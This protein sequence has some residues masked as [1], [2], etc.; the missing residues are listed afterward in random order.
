MRTI[1][2]FQFV[3]LHV[4]SRISDSWNNSKI[5]AET[6]RG[7]L[8]ERLGDSDEIADEVNP[9][10]DGRIIYNA[11]RIWRGAEI[12]QQPAFHSLM[13]DADV[14]RDSAAGVP[15]SMCKAPW[16]TSDVATA[17]AAMG[18]QEVIWHLWRPHRLAQTE[19]KRSAAQS[20]PHLKALDDAEKARLLAL[21]PWINKES[22]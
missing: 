3:P 15:P 7:W 6:L 20:H 9:V 19:W 1:Q 5:E 16:R 14:E 10:L 22:S 2:S 13:T 4:W 11:R 12:I 8:E 21:T 18:G 17:T